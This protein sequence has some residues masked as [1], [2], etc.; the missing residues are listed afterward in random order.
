MSGKQAK[1]QRAQAARDAA[2]R[3]AEL[4]SRLDGRQFWHGGAPGLRIGTMLL[5]AEAARRAG[6]WD[7]GHL[8]QHGYDDGTTDV[9]QVYFTTDRELARAFCCT[10]AGGV[11]GTLYRVEPIGPVVPDP[12]F[13]GHDVS[14]SARGAVI[15]DVDEVDVTLTPTE[16]AAR[17]GLYMAWPSREPMYDATGR[18]LLSAEQRARGVT[19]E[20]ADSRFARWT[21]YDNI[22]PHLLAAIAAKT[23]S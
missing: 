4:A 23:P 20:W 5:T 16:R 14:F 10:L 8:G 21:P 13:D 7:T 9:G 11:R 17:F 3:A 18:F 12:D 15:V 22:R 6:R 19:Q 1:A 2:A